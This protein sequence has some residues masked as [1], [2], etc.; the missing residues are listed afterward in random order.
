MAPASAPALSASASSD[1][2]S[3]VEAPPAVALMPAATKNCAASDAL[4][5]AALADFE[6][7]SADSSAFSAWTAA[8]CT[9]DETAVLLGRLGAADPDPDVTEA[10]L[11]LLPDAE[12]GCSSVAGSSALDSS[13]AAGVRI[14]WEV[15]LG[16]AEPLAGS[17]TAV[18]AFSTASA[19]AA[20]EAATGAS[21]DAGT[22]ASASDAAAALAVPAWAGCR[23]VSGVSDAALAVASAD[24]AEAVN[25]AWGLELCAEFAALLSCSAVVSASFAAASAVRVCAPASTACPSVDLTDVCF[26]VAV[27]ALASLAADVSGTALE[28]SCFVGSA[29]CLLSRS[30]A[31]AV[32]SLDASADLLAATK[33]VWGL[34]L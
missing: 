23:T 31:L 7:V 19:S 6:D 18:E 13:E 15:E 17:R 25:A 29:A 5:P 1:E 4:C 26:D 21:S 8:A 24:D 16:D 20:V 30:S 14:C 28:G 32:A 34:E 11:A 2:A 33:A 3:S 10:A 27:A 12:A 9:D 22:E